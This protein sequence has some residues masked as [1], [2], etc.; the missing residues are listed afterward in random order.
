MAAH[1]RDRRAV[2]R[3]PEYRL[4]FEPVRGRGIAVRSGDGTQLHVELFG[5]EDAPPI[6]LVH[7]WTCGLRFWA[8]RLPRSPSARS[9][10]SVAG[11]PCEPAA[12]G[13][14]RDSI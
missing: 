4:L 2:E 14:S 8:R 7:G 5:D 11:E 12:G 6:V 3:D 9:S 1:R 10:C 13:S